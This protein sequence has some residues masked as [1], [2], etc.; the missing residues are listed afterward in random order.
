MLHH[1]LLGLFKY[2]R[3][4]F[5]IMV[6]EDSDPLKDLV[7]LATEHG[8]VL[9]RQSERDF[10]KTTFYNGITTAKLM[11]REYTGV[12]LLILTVLKSDLGASIL[13]KK[14]KFSED[15][16]LADWILLLETLLEWE[17]WMRSPT[18]Q[19]DEVRKART[20]HRYLMYLIKKV[21]PRNKGMGWNTAKFHGILHLAD[22]ILNC[23]VPLEVDTGSCEGHHKPA[24]DAAKLTQKRKST[25][26]KQT[27]I[28]MLELELLALC[29]E[30]LA[31][32]PVWDYWNGYQ[33]DP[34]SQEAEAQPETGGGHF[35]CKM[36]P[37]NGQ[38]CFQQPKAH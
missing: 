36:N 38:Y 3:E 1:I 37:T 15:F 21:A 16:V 27:A 7:S 5:V 31:G 23:G 29:L 26:D 28:R 11:A 24:K 9:S 32:R 35:L 30:E 20:K 25:F 12:L 13:Q 34:V 8:A 22:D 19:K 2:V 4:V 33:H 14:K 18:L 10:P 17:A 6:G